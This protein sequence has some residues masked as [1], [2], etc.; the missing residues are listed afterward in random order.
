MNLRTFYRLFYKHRIAKASFFLR[1]YIFIIVP[2]KYI[3]NIFYFE[4]KV[5]LDLYKNQISELSK[6]NLNALFEHFN[7]DKGEYFI[8]QYLQPAKK[9]KNKIEAHGYAKIY[10]EIFNVFK[11]KNINIL[12]LGSFYGNAAAALFFYFDKANIFSGDI[13]PDMFKYKSNR[14]KN[15]YIDSSSR[16]SL[17][18]D[19]ISKKNNFDIIIEDASHMLKDQIISLFMLFPLVNSGGYFIVEE[20]DF[21]ETREDMRVNQ[22][23]PDLKQILQ[24]ILKNIDFNSIYIN[25]D[26]KKYFLEN[27][28]SIE[29]KKGNFN[30]IAIIK[31]K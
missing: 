6:K 16:N 27:F 9:N 26:E 1:L 15:F 2:L 29:I 10:E 12:E 30:E 31:K 11:K 17:E 3:I 5:N 21:P 20:L 18:N 23:K 22:T 19:L 24:N 28:S 25:D 8:N 7:S 4:K 14:I 13:N